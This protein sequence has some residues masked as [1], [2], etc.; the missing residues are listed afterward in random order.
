[1]DSQNSFKDESSNVTAEPN[2]DQFSNLYKS[3]LKV[4]NKDAFINYLLALLCDRIGLKTISLEYL[5]TSLNQYPYNWSCWL[6]LSRHVNSAVTLNEILVKLPEMLMKT[7]FKIQVL[8]EL[9][10][11][12]DELALPLIDEISDLAP[13]FANI[14][15]AM[16]YHNKRGTLAPNVDFEMCEEILQQ[17][18]ID[19]P[20]SLEAMDIY[21]NILYVKDETVKLSELAQRAVKIDKFRPEVNILKFNNH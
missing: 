12:S 5:I 20:Y 14:Q 19:N 2:I 1:L 7:C 6:S 11:E 9:N 4:E 8:N 15:L 10:E 18:S 17:I 21:S 16:V 13:K 3:V